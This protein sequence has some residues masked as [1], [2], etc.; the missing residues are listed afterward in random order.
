MIG[1]CNGFQ[2]IVKIG[3]L[4]GFDKNYEKQI[5]TLTTN[6]S[7]K[8]EDRW[9]H[10][11]VNEKSNCIFTKGIKE[12][13]LP[14]RHGEGKFIASRD[15]I[16]RLEKENQIVLKYIDPKTKKPT[17][18]YPKNPNGA[19]NSIAGICNKEGNIFGLMPHPEAA[20]SPYLN[21]EW[22]RLKVIGKIPEVTSL[23]IFKNAVEHANDNLL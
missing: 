21:P 4:P 6:D 12:L 16:E 20:F 7:G 3:L 9:V 13:Y 17:T 22:T 2:V 1:I 5:A 19:L 23:K 8:F 11:K 18:Q 14:V 15:V 10:L